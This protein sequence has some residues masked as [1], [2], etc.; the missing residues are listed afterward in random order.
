MPFPAKVSPNCAR[1]D[2]TANR[3]WEG[4]G[5]FSKRPCYLCVSN[6]F[7]MKSVFTEGAMLTSGFS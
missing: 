7:Q 5:G 3:T 2:N 1:F 4:F 6:N